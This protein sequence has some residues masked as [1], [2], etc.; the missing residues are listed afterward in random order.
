MK[1]YCNEKPDYLWISNFATGLVFGEKTKQKTFTKTLCLLH[2][3]PASDN[4]SCRFSLNS[5]VP[6]LQQHGVTR[7]FLCHLRKE[8]F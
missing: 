3:V 6:P 5:Q 2:L 7:N 1:I 4:R 8:F